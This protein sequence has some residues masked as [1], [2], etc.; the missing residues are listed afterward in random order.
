M[1]YP[2]FSAGELEQLRNWDPS[3][4]SN[5]YRTGVVTPTAD[6]PTRSPQ[7]DNPTGQRDFSRPGESGYVDPTWQQGEHYEVANILNP[8]GN[9][10]PYKIPTSQELGDMYAGGRFTPSPSNVPAM[11]SG[12]LDQSAQSFMSQWQLNMPQANQLDAGQYQQYVPQAI[13]DQAKQGYGAGWQRAAFGNATE[14]MGQQYARARDVTRYATERSGFNASGAA[15]NDINSAMGDYAKGAQ[16]AL[17]G[18][19]QQN[20][21]AQL[22]AQNVT[23]NIG[24]QNAQATADVGLY[25]D[26]MRRQAT[27]QGQQMQSNISDY[28][29]GRRQDALGAQS[30]IGLAQESQNWQ[31][32][33]FEKQ[34]EYLNSSMDR[35][36]DQQQSQQELATKLGYAQLGGSALGW[37]TKLFGG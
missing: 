10:G 36:W 24:V 27:Q 31:N 32:M 8:Q 21:A 17:S 19:E 1:P 26:Q 3:G 6:R 11:D 13:Q 16:G 5:W 20:Q 23:A 29:S 28:L 37:L 25:N 2:N 15:Q 22:N 33:Q 9:T 35:Q 7:V 18:I 30:N 12:N 4:L 34:L 14:G